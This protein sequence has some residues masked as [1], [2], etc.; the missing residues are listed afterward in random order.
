MRSPS[1]GGIDPVISAPNLQ[2][3]ACRTRAA[4]GFTPRRRALLGV[5]TAFLVTVMVP[6]QVVADEPLVSNPPGLV[7]PY[8]EAMTIVVAP[9][10]KGVSDVSFTVKLTPPQA[11]FPLRL[12]YSPYAPEPA[13]MEMDGAVIGK[14]MLD[15]AGFDAQAVIVPGGCPLMYVGDHKLTFV[16]VVMV[17]HVDWTPKWVGGC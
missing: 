2:D 9:G 7:V 4:G 6:G 3:S 16:G 14:V 5:L 13:A 12:G 8:G 1:F 11:D 17:V 15:P 10:D